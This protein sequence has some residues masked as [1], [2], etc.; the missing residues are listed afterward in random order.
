MSRTY[1]KLTYEFSNF[2]EYVTDYLF[3]KTRQEAEDKAHEMA[4]EVDYTEINEVSFD[5][6]K[7]H[8]TIGEFEKFFDV[9]VEEPYEIVGE[10]L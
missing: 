7:C 6:L 4:D 3:F 9:K 1:Y 2:E 8:M 5:E 10:E